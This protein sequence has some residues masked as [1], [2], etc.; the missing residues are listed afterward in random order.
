[1]PHADADLSHFICCSVRTELRGVLS[2]ICAE[3]RLALND[4]VASRLNGDKIID[5]NVMLGELGVYEINFMLKGTA[6]LFLK[7]SL[8]V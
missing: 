7:R 3:K 6:I 5:T 4:F 1:M 8:V 2:Q